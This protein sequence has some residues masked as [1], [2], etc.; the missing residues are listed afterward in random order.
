VTIGRLRLALLCLS[1]A[2]L[3]SCS[4]KSESGAFADPNLAASVGRS[5]ERF[6]RKFEELRRADPN[7]EPANIT[8]ND[9]APVSYTTEPERI[10]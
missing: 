9:V 1:G 4:D 3:S 2:P 7:S 6:G 8:E 5:D 10:D